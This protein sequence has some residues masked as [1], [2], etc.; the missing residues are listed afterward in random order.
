[1]FLYQQVNSEK[2]TLMWKLLEKMYYKIK[3]N[4][5]VILIDE[6]AFLNNKTLYI[7]GM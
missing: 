4:K 5:L 2:N 7:L 6:I 1:M 3:V